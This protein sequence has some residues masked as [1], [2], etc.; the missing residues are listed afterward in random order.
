MLLEGKKVSG[1]GAGIG[2]VEKLAVVRLYRTAV[3]SRRVLLGPSRY[4]PACL[5]T[6]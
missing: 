5:E 3:K 4:S 6:S 2:R 1:G